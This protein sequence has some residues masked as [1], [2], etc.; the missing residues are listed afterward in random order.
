MSV[1]TSLTARSVASGA[2]CALS[3]VVLGID[4]NVILLD[5][6]R[7]RLGDVG[8]GFASGQV[9]A[10][11]DVD[12]IALD[13]GL[14]RAQERLARGEVVLPAVPRAGQQ[15]RLGVELEVA[16]AARPR[17]RRDPPLAQ[18]PTLVRAA[19]ANAVEAIPDPEDADRPA[20]HGDD[21]PASRLEVVNGRDDDL[22][23]APAPRQWSH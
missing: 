22:H 16:R 10:G 18:R 7:E 15:R 1:S 8:A 19:V 3:G 11:L 14:A 13:A 9:C 17:P 21:P 6:D 4:D 2:A 23:R 20:A 12:V 5:V